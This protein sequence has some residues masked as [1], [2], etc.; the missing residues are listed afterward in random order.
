MTLRICHRCVYTDSFA[1][2]CHALYLQHIHVHRIEISRRVFP[3]LLDPRILSVESVDYF[4]TSDYFSRR[5]KRNNLDEQNF[6]CE[7]NWSGVVNFSCI[8]MSLKMS[9][10]FIFGD[11][12]VYLSIE[13]Q[14]IAYD[15]KSKYPE[16]YSTVDKVGTE[17]LSSEEIL[18]RVGLIA[19]WTASSLILPLS[20]DKL[21][22]KSYF[23]ARRAWLSE[24]RRTTARGLIASS[25]RILSPS[26][27]NA[28]L[29]R[30][31]LFP[32][33]LLFVV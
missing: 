21:R 32:V 7:A 19:S 24:E 22:A 15:I 12:F 18:F 1:L 2:D 31:F 25:F 14:I 8:Q 28:T 13:K 11:N 4:E 16:E 6:G 17:N 3:A 9:I 20:H 33:D 10:R 27:R 29:I 23:F 26:K 5:K 30:A